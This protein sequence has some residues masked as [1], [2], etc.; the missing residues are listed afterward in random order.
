MSKSFE[1]TK[2]TRPSSAREDTIRIQMREIYILF[3]V[4]ISRSCSYENTYQNV[5]NLPNVSDQ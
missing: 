5:A 2:F 3:H 4:S 1:V